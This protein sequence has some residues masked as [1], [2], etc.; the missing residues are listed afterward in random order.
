MTESPANL[1]RNEFIQAS[2][3]YRGG[4]SAETIQERYGLD[5][6]IKLSANEC[7][8]PPSPK[9]VE[10]IKSA[11][12][13]LNR[14]YPYMGDDPLREALAQAIGR[15][16]THENFFT[17][18][19]GCDV[20]SLITSSFLNEGDE[21]IIC[22]PTFPVYDLVARR[23]GANVVYVDLDPDTFTYDVEAIL[24]NITERT[25]ILYLCT[26]N[27]PTGTLLTA[28]QMDTII[29][30]LPPHVLA[31]SDEVYYHFNT[32]DEFPD[33]L[34]HV[35]NNRNV[36]IVHSFSKVYGLAGL[37]LGYGIAPLEVADYLNRAREPYHLSTVTMNAAMAA[38][39]DAE[40]TQRT[41]E[42]TVS[43]REWIEEQLGA[44]S[45]RY[46]PSQA[47]FVTFQ[48]PQPANEVAQKLE[49][50]GVVV[51]PLERFYLPD[52]IR[53]TVS[54]QAENERF[55]DTLK[56]VVQG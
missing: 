7:M 32:S 51:R 17:G 11:A 20:L 37:R 27:N 56:D 3:I 49:E 21:C 14:Y 16:T 4:T 40:H 9:A 28:E 55:I 48:P 5:D 31:V 12:G 29:D 47:N 41:V 33:T 18:N 8:F 46:W 22:R 42:L 52:H 34:K 24:S 35:H 44:M 10:A 38:I 25:R 15:S 53:V 45:V 13:S 36:V 2:P 1:Q 6:V 50:R 43:G 19:G 26:P 54:Y 30:N 23:R 39:Q